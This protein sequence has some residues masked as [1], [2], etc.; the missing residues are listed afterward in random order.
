L[1]GIL[2]TPGESGSRA[3][4][5]EKVIGTAEVEEIATRASA[6][7]VA[8]LEKLASEMRPNYSAVAEP[9]IRRRLRLAADDL[10]SGLADDLK[11]VSDN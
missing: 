5:Q 3:R 11:H 2:R 9:E 1:K 6:R 4:G 7:I 10:K 8:G